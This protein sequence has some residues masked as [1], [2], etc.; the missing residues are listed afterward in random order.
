MRSLFSNIVVAVSGSPASVLAAKY[1]IVLA[2]LY[3]C[4]LSAVY[5][6]DEATLHKLTTSRILVSDES[7][8]FEN[9]L[10]KNGE[11]Y[12]SYIEDLAKAKGVQ[13]E[14]E[15]RYGAIWSELVRAAQEKKADLIILGGFEK[16]RDTKDIITHLHRQILLAAKCSVLVAKEPDIDIMYRHI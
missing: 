10:R 6:V 16:D 5:V 3:K 4:S 13:M 9:S 14:K 7:A 2:K 8:E 11:R 15:L 12:L 1:A